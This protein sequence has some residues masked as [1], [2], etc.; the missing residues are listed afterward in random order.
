MSS[1][2]TPLEVHLAVG[3]GCWLKSTHVFPAQ[4]LH[5]PP[6]QVWLP[7]VQPIPDA[8]QV[9]V[10]PLVHVQ[11]WLAMPLQLPSSPGSHVSAAFG[12]TEQTPQFPP[13]HFVVPAAQ[14]PSNCRSLPQLPVW[15]LRHVQPSLAILLQVAS[16]PVSQVSFGAG[17]ISPAQGPQ[18]VAV[19]VASNSH[20]WVPALHEPTPA[21]L[22]AAS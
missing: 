18:T 12:A 3:S 15:P 16:S 5:P 2:F 19:F 1:L 22:A 4:P 9:M 14:L 17:V 20:T 11:P 8:P 21:V 6:W 7:K 10:W 13:A